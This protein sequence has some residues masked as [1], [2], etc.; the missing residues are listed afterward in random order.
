MF[1][2]AS[3]LESLNLSFALVTIVKTKGIVPRKSG[4]MVVLPD[5]SSYGTVGGGD[6]ER[7]A[8]KAKHIPYNPKNVLNVNPIT[9]HNLIAPDISE[10][11]NIKLQINVTATT[12]III[13][14]TIPALTAASPSINAP[15]IL[16]AEP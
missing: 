9:L 1:E 11:E 12:I 8:I 2:I 5:G 7:N 16:I 14:L 4:R 13:G 3:K 6:L 15:S 10:S